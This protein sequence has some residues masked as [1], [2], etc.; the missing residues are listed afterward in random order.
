VGHAV[1]GRHRVGAIVVTRIALALVALAGCELLVDIPNGSAPVDANLGD[2]QSACDEATDCSAPT[3]LCDLA[4]GVC[5]ECL[6]STD[7]T[8]ATEPVCIDRACAPCSDDDQCASAVCL[9]DG[10]CADPTRVLYASPTGT[11]VLCSQGMPCDVDTAF[12]LVTPIRDIIDLADGAYVRST[13]L[14]IAV[15]LVVSGYG[16]TFQ[17]TTAQNEALF[18]VTEGGDLTVLG[19][20]TQATMGLHVTCAAARL[21]LHRTRFDG[22]RFTG[23]I[24]CEVAIERATIINMQYYGLYIGGGPMTIS[25]SYIVD[26]GGMSVIG[27]LYTDSIVSGTIEYT[28]IAHNRHNGGGQ[29]TGALVCNNSTFTVRNSIFAGNQLPG[30]QPACDVDY[31]VVDTGFVGGPNNQPIDPMF[32]APLADDFHLSPASPARGLADPLS[33]MAIDGDGE[34]RPQPVGGASD[35]GADEIP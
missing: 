25:N 1:V 27:G 20:S 4:A 26:N 21:R 11:D 3:P 35:P 5:V 17:S 6:E 24:L 9:P 15:P 7:C 30:I 8:S 19:L 16:A 10:A 13:P 14:N 23:T 12:T 33:V 32:V 2:G 18:V 22:G 31:S 34:P 29:S 28:T